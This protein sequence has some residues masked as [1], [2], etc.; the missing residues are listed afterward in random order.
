MF[1]SILSCREGDAAEVTDVSSLLLL[2]SMQSVT[3]PSLPTLLKLQGLHK[4][5]RG[6]ARS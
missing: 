4:Y 5:V 2:I 6:A 3:V 1:R